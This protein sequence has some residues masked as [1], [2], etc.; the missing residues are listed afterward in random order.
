MA[1]FTSNRLITVQTV[2][3]MLAVSDRTVWRLLKEG[4]LPKPLRIGRSVRWPMQTVEDYL[5]AL[6]MTCRESEPAHP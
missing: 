2:A 1:V 4:R 5:E 6:C 3:Q